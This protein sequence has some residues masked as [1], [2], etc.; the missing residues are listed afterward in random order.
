MRLRAN[1]AVVGAD[2]IAAP[3]V[4][5]SEETD[6]EP[7]LAS[8]TLR[9]LTIT[10]GGY[11]KRTEI[12]EFNKQRRGGQGVRAHKMHAARGKVVTGF[13]VGDDDHLL[14]INDA[15]V[16][17]RTKVSSISVQGRTASGVRV[18]NLDGDSKVA[19][20]ARVLSGADADDADDAESDETG[21][22][23]GEATETNQSDLE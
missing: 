6:Q 15:G 17:I 22:D 10:D 4:V 8:Q 11:G 18:M 3:S 20:V 21:T 13:L 1:D 14:M 12:E 23:A 7:A 5:P 2:S 19:A 9:L 16:V